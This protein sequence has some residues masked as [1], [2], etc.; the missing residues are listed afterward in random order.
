MAQITVNIDGKSYRM[1][2]EE[3]QEEHL[4][5]LAGRFDRYVAHLK[6]EFGEIGDLRLTVMAGILVM[7]ELSEAQRMLSGLESES[8]SLKKTRDTALT[9]VEEADQ[10]LAKTLAH[11]THQVERIAAKLEKS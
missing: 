11:I 10:R 3:G 6:D 5:D 7:D 4:S 1:A 9:R 2:C 8:N